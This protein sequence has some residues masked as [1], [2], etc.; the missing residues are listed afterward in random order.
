MNRLRKHSLRW[1]LG[2]ALAA[3]F[4][5]GA[6]KSKPA[7][8]F[9]E[10][11]AALDVSGWSCRKSVAITGSGAQQLDLDLDV[12]SHAQSD[13]R[14][15]RLMRGGEQ[16]PYIIESAAIGRTLA[17]LVTVTNLTKAPTFTR[18]TL[19]L[20][21]ANLPATRLTCTA[22]TPLFQ[23]DITLYELVSDERGESLRH[24]LGTYNTTWTQTPDQKNKEF[25]VTLNDPPRTDS[26]ILETPNG[27]NQPIELENFLVSY[28]AKRILFAAKP[29]DDLFLYYG[30]LSANSPRYDLS[31]V[32]KN[33]TAADKANAAL[34]AEELLKQ[35]P[36]HATGTSGKGGVLFW[37]ILALVVVALLV[38]IARLLP[39]SEAQPPK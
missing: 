39:K 3:G 10:N 19:K 5:L 33:L 29:G 7:P 11:G 32:A 38:V 24:M 25:A 4:S 16:V 8:D 13:F 9:P 17:P 2:L 1:L 6:L 22:R 27:D 15:L 23:R 30:N 14:D 21:R 36:W 28:S 20:P 31:L 35:S 37:G 18:W 12:L 34:G 26:I